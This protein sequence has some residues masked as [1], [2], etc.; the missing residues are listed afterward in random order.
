MAE[1]GQNYSLEDLIENVPRPVPTMTDEIDRSQMPFLKR[2]FKPKTPMAREFQVTLY[3]RLDLGYNLAVNSSGAA[4]L[5]VLV[6]VGKGPGTR[7]NNFYPDR[8]LVPGLRVL[9]VNGITDCLE[10]VD[11]LRASSEAVIRLRRP[12][13]HRVLINREKGSKLG[14][15]LLEFDDESVWVDQVLTEGTVPEWNKQNPIAKITTGSRIVEVNGSRGLA[16]RLLERLKK[17]GP[18]ELVVESHGPETAN[19]KEP[20][21]QDWYPP[22]PMGPTRKPGLGG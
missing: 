21:A 1:G 10:L 6:H 11:E 18:I 3:T 15:K 14:V 4:G 22:P 5:A 7:W 17:D 8:Q 12:V 16:S 9:E 2:C 13:E 19:E 20:A